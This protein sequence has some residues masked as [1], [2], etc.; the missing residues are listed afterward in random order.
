MITFMLGL[1]IMFI[2]LIL[3]ALLI[4]VAVQFY[5]RHQGPGKPTFV[6][7]VTLIGSVMVV[8]VVG[9][10]LQIGVW[11]AVFVQLGEFEDLNTAFYHSAVNFATLGY[12]DIV[13]SEAHRVLGPVQAINGVLMVGV[14]TS[15]LMTALQDAVR[16][17]REAKLSAI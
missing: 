13:M 3:Q 7:T 2:C 1:G 17:T 11:G 12:G 9:N 16:R 8:L 6:G 4:T 14:S 15:V 10:F 5:A